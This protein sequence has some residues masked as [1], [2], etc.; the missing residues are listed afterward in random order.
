MISI[1][2]ALKYDNIE[3]ILSCL[4]DET[5]NLKELKIIHLK[6]TDL[7]KIFNNIY[8]YKLVCTLFNKFYDSNYIQRLKKSINYYYLRNFDTSMLSHHSLFGDYKGMILNLMLKFI[9]EK[10]ILGRCSSTYSGYAISSNNLVVIEP[11][12]RRSHKAKDAKYIINI[13]SVYDEKYNII[14]RIGYI[15]GIDI[16]SVVLQEHELP[17]I[18]PEDK[19]IRTHKVNERITWIY[20]I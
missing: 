18:F 17:H 15:N 1:L 12:G 4:S 7:L 5:A 19:K 13:Y 10:E 20:I 11:S 3:Y 6:Y 9:P 8:K 14:K 16:Y 2:D